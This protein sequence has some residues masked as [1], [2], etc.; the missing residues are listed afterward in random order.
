MTARATGR[1]SAQG[2]A[3][4]TATTVADLLARAQHVTEELKRCTDPVS[5]NQWEALDQ[6]LYRLLVELAGA[7]SVGPGPV[8]RAAVP[9]YDIV[10][11]YPAPL[12]PA[13]PTVTEFTACEAARFTGTSR[14]T[15][16][17]RILRGALPARRNTD[18]WLIPRQ[19]LDLRDVPPGDAG[20]PHP[21]VKLAVTFG[22]LTDVLHGHQEDPDKPFL[23]TGAVNRLAHD[24]LDVS[25]AATR[26]AIGLMALRDIERPLAIAR[27][28]ESAVERLAPHAVG[29]SV[30]YA[31]VPPPARNHPGHPRP[32]ARG[33]SAGAEVAGRLD[34][35]LADWVRAAK[36]EAAAVVP[37]TDVIRNVTAQ[38]IHLYAA[39]DALLAAEAADRLSLRDASGAAVAREELREA[40]QALQRSGTSWGTATTG[41]RPR[42]DY[43]DAAQRLHDVLEDVIQVA[44]RL[45]RE[46]ASAARHRLLD[47]LTAASHDLTAL[48]HENAPAARRLIDAGAL[49]AP[50]R[51]LQSAGDRLHAKAKGRFVP[52][53]FSDHPGLLEAA[54][55]AETAAKAAARALLELEAPSRQ[56]DHVLIGGPEL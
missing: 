3:Y 18:G 47:S 49:L 9:L 11:R 42:R 30:P 16:G 56:F 5:L 46:L 51:A 24:V 7:R 35:A 50:A 53:W 43:I 14:K 2:Y 37:S 23:T 48:L 39:I 31:A 1:R 10:K 17:A 55:V 15:I 22:A 8:D 38:G 34:H 13:I 44:P 21:L 32:E 40:A 41:M 36:A 4:P 52:V 20:D 45:D 28:A 29:Q 26:H 19:S 12:A 25:V 33:T 27:H 6:A 54:V